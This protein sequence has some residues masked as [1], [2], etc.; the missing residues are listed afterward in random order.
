MTANPACC[1]PDTSLVDVGRLLIENDCGAIPVVDDLN[2]RRPI[3]MITDRDIACRAVAEGRDA[4]NLTAGGCMSSPCVT[5]GP[6]GDAGGLLPAHGVE[7]DP[8]GRGRGQQR[9]VSRDRRPG[10]RDAG[11]EG[12]EGG[13]RPSGLGAGSP[14]QVKWHV[15]CISPGARFCGNSNLSRQNSPS[16]SDPPLRG[17]RSPVHSGRFGHPEGNGT[18][19]A[20]RRQCSCPKGQFSRSLA[21]RERRRGALSSRN[22]KRSANV[23][24]TKE[25]LQVVSLR[26]SGRP[27]SSFSS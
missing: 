1:E 7:A 9:S 20:V 4:L 10:R 14:R 5:A 24:L 18:C 27:W 25:A 13:A 23:T 3:G 11:R 19:T 12:K 21:D 26:S 6:R 8:P 22:G 17:R 2:R 16:D 15:Y